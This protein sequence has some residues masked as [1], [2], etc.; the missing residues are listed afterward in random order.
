[1][2]FATPN[3]AEDK[4]AK[5]LLALEVKTAPSEQIVVIIV[6]PWNLNLLLERKIKVGDIRQTTIP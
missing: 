6:S 5:A 1:M 2:S 3:A 4:L